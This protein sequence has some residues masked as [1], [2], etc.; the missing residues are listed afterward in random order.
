MAEL[1]ELKLLWKESN[2]EPITGGC[3]REEISVLLQGRS[4]DIKKQIVKRLTA[5]IKTYLLIGGLF[6]VFAIVIS[7]FNNLVYFIG[8]CAVLPILATL[9]Y[10]EYR[11]RT[12]PMS[13]SL[14]ESISALIHAIDS[15]A[16]LYLLAYVG[17]ILVALTLLEFVLVRANGWNPYAIIRIPIGVALIWWNYVSGRRYA[18]RLFQTYRSDLVKTLNDLEGA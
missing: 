9:A 12:L 17:T 16:R 14:R 2:T 3:S 11:L 4:A 15:G 13:G 18:A 7:G 6:L 5:E 10:Q 1:T 8:A